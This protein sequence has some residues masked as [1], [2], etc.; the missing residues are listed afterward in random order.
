MEYMTFPDVVTNVINEY[1][2]NK[3]IFGIHIPAN[4]IP[5]N[6]PH[7]GVFSAI[8]CSSAQGIISCFLSGADI[9]VLPPFDGESFLIPKICGSDGVLRFTDCCS[10]SADIML[11]EYIKAWLAINVLSKEFNIGSTD[12]SFSIYCQCRPNGISDS[13]KAI[14]NQFSD[15]SEN[16]LFLNCKQWLCS[17]IDLFDNVDT[18]YIS[19]ISAAPVKNSIIA[20]CNFSRSTVSAY[21]DYL[22]TELHLTADIQLSPTCLGKEYIGNQLRSLWYDCAV[23]NSAVFAHAPDYAKVEG[24]I[25]SFKSKYAEKMGVLVGDTLD[26]IYGDAASKLCGKFLYPFSLSIAAKIYNTFG[27]E[28]KVSF[29]GGVSANNADILNNIGFDTIY[30][31]DALISVGGFNNLKQIQQ[32]TRKSSAGSLTVTNELCLAAFSDNSVKMPI[33]PLQSRKIGAAA[34]MLNCTPTP[35][36]IGCPIFQDIPAYIRAM[37]ENNL[38][39]AVKIITERNPLPTITGTICPH[40]CMDKCTRNHCD[41]AVDI[42]GCKLKIADEALAEHINSIKMPLSNDKRVAIVGGGAAGLSAAYLLSKVGCSVTIFEKSDRL[43]GIVAGTIPDFRISS[44]AIE[45]DIALCR[46]YGAEIVLNHEISDIDKLRK[47]GFEYIVLAIGAGVR[48]NLNLTGGG[49]IN[50]IDFLTEF[51]KTGGKVDIGKNIVVIGGGNTAM[52]AARAAIRAQGVEKVRLVYRRTR[53]YMPADEEELALAIAD[54]VEFCELL[55]PAA[56]NGSILKCTK[57]VLGAPDEKGRRT[58]VATDKIINIAADTVIA[59]VGEHIDSEFYKKC[60]IALNDRGYPVLNK[61]TS[62]TNVKNL[63]VIGDGSNGPATVV[64]AIADATKV[65]RA[66]C[67]SNALKYSARNA[68]VNLQSCLDKRGILFQ[69]DEHGHTPGEAC[70]SCSKFCGQCVDVCPTR[71]N[72]AINVKNRMQIVHI[73]KLC[74]KCG[75]CDLFCHYDC[76]PVQSKFTKFDSIA[77]FEASDNN[78]FFKLNDNECIVRLNGKTSQ[79]NISGNTL[80]EPIASLLKV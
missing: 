39:K 1:N 20:P 17:H 56:L 29:F 38:Q 47:S 71:A 6:H 2:I 34:P 19:E 22:I 59:A 80:P 62:E 57:M 76:S 40:K 67:G 52:D 5:E 45:S 35:C 65:V 36:R 46:A 27:K 9:C 63:F 10:L 18:G 23:P 68:A 15:I 42:R 7:V 12:F 25:R 49:S 73:D 21:L 60:G 58:P 26:V 37:N 3:T 50:A 53:R 54:G 64:E 16:A 28:L 31:S 30:C 79:I 78:G 55:A 66:V 77:G 8:H 51:K 14:L 75:I 72:I 4:K 44:S 24:S 33:K 69:P 70:L 41:G 43:G 61:S 13:A 32:R 74:S 11:G 48:G